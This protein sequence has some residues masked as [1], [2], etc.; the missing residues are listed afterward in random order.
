VP[1]RK[2]VL[3]TRPEALLNP[4]L[5][6]GD[7][8]SASVDSEGRLVAG[9]RSGTGYAAIR[10]PAETQLPWTLYMSSAQAVNEAGMLARQRFLLLVMTVMVLF[11][12]AGAYFIARAIRGDL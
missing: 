2:A 12:I 5:A 6:G 3:V 9:R 11:L 4:I 7:I 10:T 1:G 8:F